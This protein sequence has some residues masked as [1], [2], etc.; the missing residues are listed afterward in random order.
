LVVIWSKNAKYDLKN[1]LKKSKIQSQQKLKKYISS[2]I[3]Y[4]KLLEH[5]PKLGKVF[6]VYK[7]IEI[8][9]LIFKIHKIF[10]FIQNDKIIIVKVANP[11]QDLSNI[12]KII[13]KYFKF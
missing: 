8:R 6:Y 3:I 4:T 7:N 12:I 1:Y 5:F 9:Q 13:K 11:S 10:Y 2:L